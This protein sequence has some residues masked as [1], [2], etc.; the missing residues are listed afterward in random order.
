[1]VTQHFR[2]KSH[3]TPNYPKHRSQNY[4][5]LHR[6]HKHL[7]STHRNRNTPTQNPPQTPCIA[8][9]T[10]NSTSYTSSSST[11]K[12]KPKSQTNETNHFRK[13]FLHHKPRR[14]PN[15]Y[16]RD[17]HPTKHQRNTSLNSRKPLTI[18]QTIQNHKPTRPAHKQRRTNSPKENTTHA[19]T[20]QNKKNTIPQKLPPQNHPSPLC[21]LCDTQNHDTKHL[22]TCLSLPTHLTSTDLWN[23]PVAVAG[24]LALWDGAVGLPEAV[25]GPDWRNGDRDG[26]NTTTR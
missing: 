26:R 1:M 16:N 22:F 9:Q 15:Q 24:L 13:H 18:T 14:Q 4:H 3:Q 21:P 5:R 10:K 17:N 20:T 2:N 7:T 6:R 12:A 25:Q 11:Y 23:G 8:T 19:C